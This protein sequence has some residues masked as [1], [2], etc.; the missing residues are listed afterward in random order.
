M[1]TN[2]AN[3]QLAVNEQDERKPFILGNTKAIELAELEEDYLVPVFSRDNVECISH[4][5]FINVVVDAAQTYFQGEQFTEPQIRVSHEMIVR[6]RSGSGKLV[7][8][9]DK[10]D[11]GSYYQRMMFMIE[12]PGIS[13]TINGNKLNL[14]IV[15]VRTYSETNLLGNSTQKQMFRLGIGFLNKVCT[16]M[17]LQTDGVKLDIKVTNTADLYRYCIEVF[18]GYNY[19]KHIEEMK[20]LQN[21]II[22]VNSFA[23]FLGKARMYQ[24]LPSNIKNELGL[25]EFILPEAQINQAVRDY[26]SD[27]NFNGYGKPLTAWNFYQ[28]LTNYKNNYIDTTMERSVNAYDVARGI[29]A[30]IQRLDNTWDWFMS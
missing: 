17:L 3:F 15:G 30:S 20:R 27:E 4:S 10:D 19:N 29:A 23:Q 11:S 5:D 13:Y 14:Q 12:I 9:L 2:N 28:L 1:E 21:T 25:P 26:Y 16:N 22:D 7:E 8:N 24:A 6:T 18:S